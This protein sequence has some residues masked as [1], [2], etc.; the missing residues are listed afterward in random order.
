V[1]PERRRNSCVPDQ[2]FAQCMSPVLADCVE[3]VGE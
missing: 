1:K 3:E 2:L